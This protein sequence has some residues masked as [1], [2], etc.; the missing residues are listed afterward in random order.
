MKTSRNYFTAAIALL[1][2]ITADDGTRGYGYTDLFTRAG[3][4][5]AGPGL[6]LKVEF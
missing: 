2:E 5:P 6:G 3:E 1:I 4:I